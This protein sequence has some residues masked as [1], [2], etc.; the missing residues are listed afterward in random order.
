M[1]PLNK[2]HEEHEKEN[3]ERWLLTYADLITLLLAFFIL[4]FSISNVDKSKYEQLLVALGNAFG[5]MHTQNPGGQGG[6][7]VFPVFTPSTTVIPTESPTG[8]HVKPS[9]TPGGGESAAPTP[10]DTGNGGL[11]NAIEVE[12][13]QNVKNQVEGMLDKENLSADVKV[14]MRSQG[15]VISINS[16][17]LFAS[18]SADLSGDSQALINKIATILKPLS[19]N[20]IEVDGH[21]DTDKISSSQFPSNWELSS[22]RANTVLRLLIESGQLNPKKMSSRGYGEYYPIAP[23]DTPENKAK[24][25][26]VNIVI[27]KDAISRLIDINASPAPTASKK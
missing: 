1:S 11:G 26:R 8:A 14:T 24:N 6:D 2:G 17:I 19:N 16:R 21:T 25:R 23:N 7:M 18:G 9:A 22:V 3:S 4:L 13:M 20:E 12:T 27:L 10:G 15:L 5:E